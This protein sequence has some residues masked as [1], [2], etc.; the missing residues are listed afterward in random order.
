MRRSPRARRQRA[1]L[2]P[3]RGVS[4]GAGCP[5][6][7]WAQHRARR[8]AF[9]LLRC[10]TRRAARFRRQGCD[11]TSPGRAR[12]VGERPSP[13]RRRAGVA[14]PGSTPA[15]VPRVPGSSR[16]SR[17]AR[18]ESRP[19][20][21]AARR[22]HRDAG[23]QGP[24]DAHEC[25]ATRWCNPRWQVEPRGEARKGNIRAGQE[26]VGLRVIR[27]VL[28]PFPPWADPEPEHA[29]SRHRADPED[30]ANPRL[31]SVDGDQPPYEDWLQVASRYIEPPCRQLRAAR[32]NSSK[33]HPMENSRA[34]IE[35]MIVA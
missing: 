27:E 29:E 31:P 10:D 24:G 5:H 1:C 13:L 4:P 6:I 35:S 9:V 15:R 16:P 23:V 33:S 8:A 11:A 2:S 34:M 28:K 3:H 7:T 26:I 22:C 21:T 17:L 18:S 20:P 12:H 25:E 19:V 32:W 30:D 14:A